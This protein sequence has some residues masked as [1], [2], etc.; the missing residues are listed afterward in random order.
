[1]RPPGKESR[2]T[3]NKQDRRSHHIGHAKDIRHW[4]CISV[5]ENGILGNLP[6]LTAPGQG[7]LP[8]KTLQAVGQKELSGDLMGGAALSSA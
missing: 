5:H 7:N 3:E 4:T 2:A 6:A 1:L 8:K